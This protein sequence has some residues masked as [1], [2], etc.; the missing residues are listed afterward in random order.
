MVWDQHSAPE[1]RLA[2]TVKER[3]K[4]YGARHDNRSHV[5]QEQPRG[6]GL[7][8]VGTPGVPLYICAFQLEK[9]NPLPDIGVLNGHDP[10][11]STQSY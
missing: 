9:F 8:V 3:K 6:R 1:T 4:V 7:L 10:T 11:S 2:A 5:T